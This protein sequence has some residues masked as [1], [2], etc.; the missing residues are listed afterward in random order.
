MKYC[1]LL[2]GKISNIIVCWLIKA[3]CCLRLSFFFFLNFEIK[4]LH[5]FLSGTSV[6]VPCL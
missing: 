1:T 6:L 4:K 2:K 3:G 5:T